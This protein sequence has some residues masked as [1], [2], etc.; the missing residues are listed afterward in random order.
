M[1][2]ITSHTD[3]P[4]A[5]QELIGALDS[6]FHYDPVRIWAIGFGNTFPCFFAT[7]SL[8]LGTAFHNGGVKPHHTYGGLGS[9]R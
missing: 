9:D 6:V 4:A 7:A 2:R 8:A 1:Q 3:N 5:M